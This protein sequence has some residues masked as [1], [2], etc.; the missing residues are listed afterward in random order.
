MP[1]KSAAANKP[2]P[3]PVAS[4]SPGSAADHPLSPTA[5]RTAKPKAKAAPAPAAT[6]AAVPAP[7]PATAVPTNRFGKSPRVAVA[8]AAKPTQKRAKRTSA[9]KPALPM[10]AGR[11]KLR[12]LAHGIYDIRGDTIKRIQKVLNAQIAEKVE[13]CVILVTEGGRGIITERDVLKAH[14][15]C[16]GHPL[17]TCS[18]DEV[19]FSMTALLKAVNYARNPALARK[20]MKEERERLAAEAAAV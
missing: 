3:K 1:P 11:I 16:T 15:L 18:P 6:A 5:N 17:Y 12:A 14:Q 4:S 19:E 10:R 8:P 7:A 20:H 2:A 9:P 13:K